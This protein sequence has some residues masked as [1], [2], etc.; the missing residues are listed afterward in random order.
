MNVK[1]FR[2]EHNCNFIQLYLGKLRYQASIA[3]QGFF[4]VP[5]TFT[6]QK[7]RKHVKSIKNVIISNLI[8]LYTHMLKMKDKFSVSEYEYCGGGGRIFNNRLLLL[9]LKNYNK[10]PVVQQQ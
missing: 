8:S 6:Y 2:I 7:S 5:S 4:L 1:R 10:F 9:L 3:L